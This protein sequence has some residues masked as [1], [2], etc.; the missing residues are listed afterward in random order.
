MKAA[1][2]RRCGNPLRGIVRKW[3]LVFA[4]VGRT[5]FIDPKKRP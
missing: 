1:H 2:L 4:R 3:F 5:T